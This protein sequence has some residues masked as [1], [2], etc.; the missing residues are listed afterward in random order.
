MLE[1]TPWGV[2]AP[3]PSRLVGGFS[4]SMGV[5]RRASTDMPDLLPERSPSVV[6]NPVTEGAVLLSTTDEVYFGL[7]HVGVQVWENLP[8]KLTTVE[9]MYLAIQELYPEVEASTIRTDVDELLDSLRE[10]NLVVDPDPS[11]HAPD[12]E[13]GPPQS[14]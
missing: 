11:T 14:S 6:F 3:T 1:G 8:P 9:E 12:P 2:A 10:H 7:N 13:S 4:W 5:Q